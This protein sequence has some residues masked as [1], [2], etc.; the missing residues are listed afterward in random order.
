MRWA[1]RGSLRFKVCLR[2]IKFDIVR[3][4]SAQAV[5]ALVAE[6]T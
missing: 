3:K 2:Q 6:A 1:F 4:A 5:E